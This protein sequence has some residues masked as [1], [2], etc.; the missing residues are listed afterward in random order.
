MGRRI[1]KITRAAE[2]KDFIG[3]SAQQA[4]TILGLALEA[5][6]YHPSGFPH[7]PNIRPAL[8]PPSPPASATE[9]PPP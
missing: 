7:L 5:R 8:P 4:V 2:E 1:E 9:P 6:S 3:Y